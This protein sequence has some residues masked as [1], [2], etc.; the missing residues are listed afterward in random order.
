VSRSRQDQRNFLIWRTSGA[1]AIA[2]LSAAYG[3]PQAFAGSVVA[4]Y[5]AYWAGLPAGRIRLE[6]GDLGSRY[7]D[8]VEVSTKGLPQLVT[9]FRGRALVEGRLDARLPAEP[10]RYDAVYDLRKRRNSQISMRFVAQGGALVAE[11]GPGDTSHKPPLGRAFRAGA[12][13][14]ITALERIRGALRQVGKSASGGFTV[15]V[16][17]GARRFDV[18]GRILPKSHPDDAH[19]RVALTLRPI[20]GFRGEASD[21]GDP[22]SAPRPAELALSDDD[23]LLPLW[24]TVSVYHL[25]LVVWL[26]HV[27]AAAANC[28]G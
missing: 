25:P 14:P 26:D 19:L 4:V 21:D 10:A 24:M 20:A 12:V 17:D 28:P 7:R 18:L 16:Y 15:P 6:L 9:R 5:E 13:D 23:R 2:L 1:F 22:D 27:C 3:S 8:G 11:R